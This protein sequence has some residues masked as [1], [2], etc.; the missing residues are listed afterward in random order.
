MAGLFISY[1]RDDAADV[2]RLFNDLAWRC[3]RDRVFMD[4]D[5]PAGADFRDVLT[6]KL[7][8]C[9]V[10]LVVIG[11]QWL[12]LRNPETGN[13]RLDEEGDYVR[14]EVALALEKGKLV[15]PVRIAGARFPQADELPEA[16]RELAKRNALDLGRSRRAADLNDLVKQ[17]PPS[18][19]CGEEPSGHPGSWTSVLL[20]P[21][22]LLASTHVIA[23][24]WLSDWLQDW[25][26]AW[27]PVDARL[28]SVALSLVLGA[29]LAL[30][31]RTLLGER[32][33]IG[34]SIA[35]GATVLDSVLVPLLGGA[36]IVPKSGT[37]VLAFTLLF[38]GILGGYLV[39]A[40]LAALSLTRGRDGR[41][42]P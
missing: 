40:E 42:L 29:R 1:R 9:D 6:R 5:I 39:G 17:F 7:D 3:S 12:E 33:R 11:P 34:F 19:V 28:F 35:I 36:D 27:V 16:I 21:I 22:V 25:L 20:V 31:F 18:L 8:S 32:L 4:R 10:V 24:F 23:M 26:P 15:I 13:R 41:E 37:E 14:M 2:D 30:Q 38:A